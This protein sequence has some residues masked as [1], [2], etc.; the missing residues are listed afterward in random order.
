[1]PLPSAAIL[2]TASYK[3]AHVLL[4]LNLLF[5]L[6]TESRSR[7]QEESSALP[8]PCAAILPTAGYNTER[9]GRA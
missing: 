8:L 7:Q 2:P 3:T 6:T 4:W 9:V 5:M 1:M